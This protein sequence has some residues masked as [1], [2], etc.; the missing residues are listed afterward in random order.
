MVTKLRQALLFKWNGKPNPRYNARSPKLRKFS[1]S[2]IQPANKA[3]LSLV[4]ANDRRSL[5][6]D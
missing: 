5:D 6:S 3:S 4:I 2:I 1:S